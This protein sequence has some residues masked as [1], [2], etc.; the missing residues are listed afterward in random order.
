MRGVVCGVE[1]LVSAVGI[2]SSAKA[3]IIV[4]AFDKGWFRSDGHQGEASQN[5]F[6]GFGGTN[7]F[8][9]FFYFDL[10]GGSGPIGSAILKRNLERFLSTDSAE[11]ATIFDVSTPDT[12]FQITYP[13]VPGGDPTGQ[14]I[15]NDLGTGTIYGSFTV[16][17]SQAGATI[18]HAPNDGGDIIMIPLNS[19]AITDIAG[20][21]GSTF[22]VGLSLNQP[23]TLPMIGGNEE[24]APVQQQ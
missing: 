9:S 16:F 17:P 8:H 21:I 2:I 10:T 11:T 6:T 13:A 12:E 20:S 4:S 1:L 7:V 23:F 15:F 24:G 14:A 3:A 19:L 5:T 22:A 18:E